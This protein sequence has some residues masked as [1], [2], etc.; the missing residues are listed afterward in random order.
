MSTLNEFM[1]KSPYKSA[2]LSS[3]SVKARTMLLLDFDTKIEPD[4]NFFFIANRNPCF[5]I[6]VC[7][8]VKVTEADSK[9]IQQ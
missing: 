6:F 8:S 2:R 7:E 1:L 4:N 5:N 3:T 9:A